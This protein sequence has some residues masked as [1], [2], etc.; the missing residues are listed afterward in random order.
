MSEEA[1]PEQFSSQLNIAIRASLR[2]ALQK[3]ADFKGMKLYRLV[4]QILTEHVEAQKL[5]Q[6]DEA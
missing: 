4:D 5:K 3:E 1:E 2:T 6:N